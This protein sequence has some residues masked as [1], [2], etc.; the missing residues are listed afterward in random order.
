MSGQADGKG[1]TMK[2]PLFIDLKGKPVLVAGGG[3]IGGRRAEILRR[4]GADVKLVD[5]L[6]GE[7]RPFEDSDIDGCFLV[8]A[9]TDNAE[10]NA[11]ITAL[12]KQKNIFVSRADSAEDS[13]FFFPALCENEDICAGLVSNGDKHGLVKETAERI[14][15]IL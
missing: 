15:K 5:P 7:K 10:V 2:F 11:H 8:L 13:T 4:F 1:K 3:R 9:C 6:C 14:R 12:C